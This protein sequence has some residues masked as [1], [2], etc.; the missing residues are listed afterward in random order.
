MSFGAEPSTPATAGAAPG[1]HACPQCS[2]SFARLCDLNKHAKSHT[3]PY[4]CKEPGCKYNTRGWPTA[5]ELERHYNDKHSSTPRTYRCLYEPCPYWSK[6]ESN[7]KQH[8]EKAHNWEYVRSK[9]KGKRSTPQAK[10]AVDDNAAG[11]NDGVTPAG[12]NH[13]ASAEPALTD[14]CPFRSGDFVLYDGDDQADAI[15]EDDSF[16]SHRPEPQPMADAYLPWTSP[17]TRLKKAEGF[18]ERF[19]QTYKGT[20]EGQDTPMSGCSSAPGSALSP[21]VYPGAHQYPPRPGAHGS[22]IKVESP[23]L[24]LDSVFPGNSKYESI[25]GALFEPKQDPDVA[26]PGAS[27]AGQGAPLHLPKGSGTFQR[28]NSNSDNDC[29]PRKK[30]RPSPVEDFT[31]TSMPDIF[32]FAHPEIYDKSRRDRY[33]PCHTVHREI[34]TLVRHLS[35]PAH[36]LKV[37]ERYIASFDV[38]DPNYQHPR[39]G[40]CRICW[41]SFDNR[42]AFEAHVAA[43]C[44][45]VSKG[46]REKWRVLFES[47]APLRD[48]VNDASH[49]FDAVQNL[50]ATEMD[51]CEPNHDLPETAAVP[52]VSVPVPTGFSAPSLDLPSDDGAVHVVPASELARLQREHQALR[53]RNEQLERMAQALL[54]RRMYQENLKIP[55]GSFPGVT[56]TSSAHN[57]QLGAEAETPDRDSLLQHMDSQSTDVDV[58]AFLAEISDAGQTLNKTQYG[59][60]MAVPCRSTIHRVPPSPP[61]QLADYPDNGGNQPDNLKQKAMPP[62]SIADSGY[63]TEQRRGSLATL[64]NVGSEDAAAAPTGSLIPSSMAEMPEKAGVEETAS[65][66]AHGGCFAT[67]NSQPGFMADQD[68]ADYDYADPSYDIFYQDSMLQSRLSPTGF[69]FD[70]PLQTD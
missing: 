10:E 32:R 2:K 27:D 4:K 1:I 22:M 44:Q 18:I 42:S 48:S 67:N 66:F 69:A 20:Q 40:V 39:A 15:G 16:Y 9:S 25:D 54:I 28:G 37:T 35:R 43:P 61:T 68:M 12:G 46:K 14:P 58:H 29:I 13:G 26:P 57:C 34:S 23:V 30:Q 64:P 56:P 50:A 17:M 52:P 70:C 38:E 49:G 6:R 36:R 47:F 24:T 53:Q 3:R 45:K 55:A 33:S 21:L 62:P 11:S 63:C 41:Q 19:S 60:T 65:L 7:C 31:D 8:M 5:K 59:S 51:L